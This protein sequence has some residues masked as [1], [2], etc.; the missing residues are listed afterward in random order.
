MADEDLGRPDRGTRH[1]D[2]PQVTA[3]D[4]L[5]DLFHAPR[6]RVSRRTA[7]RLRSPGV[8]AVRERRR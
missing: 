3:A 2:H 7:T 8:T 6:A 4:R 5:H 1:L